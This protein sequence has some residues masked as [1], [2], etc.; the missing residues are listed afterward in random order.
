MMQKQELELQRQELKDTRKELAKTA[1]AQ[2]MLVSLTSQQLNLQKNARLKDIKP[3]LSSE[4]NEFGSPNN[5]EKASFNVNLKVKDFKLLL[6]DIQQ[7][8]ESEIYQLNRT[9][10]LKKLYDP[11]NLITVVFRILKNEYIKRQP[12]NL[13]FDIYFTDI[14]GNKY[15]QKIRFNGSMKIE[16]S[17]LLE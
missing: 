6:E 1:K 12:T 15:I 17:K 11:N 13:E 5:P 4:K 3:S 14:D 7:I 2:E 16:E 8:S 9:S 10:T